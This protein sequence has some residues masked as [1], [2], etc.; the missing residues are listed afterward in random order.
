[1][2][3][4]NLNNNINVRNIYSQEP[5]VLQ[6]PFDCFENRLERKKFIRK[7]FG[8]FLLSMLC[9]FSTCIILNYSYSAKLFINS[10]IGQVITSTSQWCLFF[11]FCAILCFNDIFRH[12]VWKYI[13][14][15]LLT[16]GISWTLGLTTTYLPNQILLSSIFITTGV[17]IGLT[18]YSLVTEMDF[19]KYIEYYFVFV[20]TVFL[21][22]IV[23]VILDSSALHIFI[24]GSGSLL[25]SFFIITDIQLI[26]GQKHIRYKFNLNDSILA[27]MNLY[28]DV[29]NLFLYIIDCMIVGIR[30]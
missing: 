10:T 2:I 21:M 29:I 27:A 18:T 4:N 28:L 25:F 15:L 13:M 17:T 9:T 24:A 5:L 12:Y 1:M 6:E 8:Y 7:T 19:T 22:S 23:S 26:V 16:F 3:E 14:Y 11:I 20:L 30:G